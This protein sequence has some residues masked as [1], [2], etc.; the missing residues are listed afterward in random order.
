MLLILLTLKYIR[1]DSCVRLATS[2]RC[3]KECNRISVMQQETWFI[4]NISVSDVVILNA[5]KTLTILFSF[6][7]YISVQLTKAAVVLW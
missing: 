2:C 5:Y 3:S 1:N 4:E 6:L 7:L